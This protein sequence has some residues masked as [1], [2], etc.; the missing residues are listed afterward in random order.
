MIVDETRHFIDFSDNPEGLL[1][2]EIL[3]QL[4]D[5]I[6]SNNHFCKL[7]FNNNRLTDDAIGTLAAIL[8]G[9]TPIE[10]LSLESCDL[11]DVDITP[12]VNAIC[13]KKA[14]K[15]INLRRNPNIT[16]DAIADIARM[17]R[18]VPTLSTIL[19]R[20]TSLESNNCAELMDA[21]E[22]S[23]FMQVVELPYTVGYRV[24]DGVRKVLR[25][26]RTKSLDN[27]YN[28]KRQKRKT[29][30]AIGGTCIE[31][32]NKRRNETREM[33]S[34]PKLVPPP[35]NTFPAGTSLTKVPQE[36]QPPPP[37]LIQPTRT[38][39]MIEFRNWADPALKNAAVHLYVLDMRCQLLETHKQERR[40]RLLAKRGIGTRQNAAE[41]STQYYRL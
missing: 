14:L 6:S 1:D 7:V 30:V 36:R 23:P 24:L 8:R 37:L 31:S 13:A 18:T 40:E 12:L 39:E 9:R 41:W 22:H 3:A 15:Y 17:I 11:R 21:L 26:D 34:L 2:G 20:G 32:N 28:A 38:L 16:S 4:R 25:K 5:A 35:C 27:T 29:T 19:L 10:Y 33:Q